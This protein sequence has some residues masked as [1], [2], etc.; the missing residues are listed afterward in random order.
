MTPANIG[1]LGGITPRGVFV[2]STC[3]PNL[4]C[5]YVKY[6]L[7]TVTDASGPKSRAVAAIP[8]QP[9]PYCMALIVQFRSSIFAKTL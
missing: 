9:R 4:S 3:V 1:G 6:R 5:S 8:R 2:S 7:N